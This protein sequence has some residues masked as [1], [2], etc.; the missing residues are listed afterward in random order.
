M[1]KH[2]ETIE[3]TRELVKLASP[4][5]EERDVMGFAL[6][7]LEGQGFNPFIHRYK[8]RTAV[9]F[10]GENVVCALEGRQGGPV[11]CLNGHL[12]TVRLAHGWTRDPYGAEIADGK[13][14]G[15]GA[16]DMKS[17]CAA[18]M[19]ALRNFVKNNADFAGKVILTLV[20][21][22]EGPYGLGT[23][24]LIEEGLLNGID[25]AI[26][27]EPSSCFTK[28][29]FPVLC[30][31]AKGAM[32]YQVDFFGKAAHAA[33]PEE[34]INA[35]VDASGFLAEMAGQKG[36]VKDILGEGRICPIAITADGGACSVPD[37]A[38]VTVY[39]HIVNGE[40]V[41]TVITEAEELLKRLKPACEYKISMRPAPTE[42]SSY[43]K[44]YVL[45]EDDRFVIKMQ[46]AISERFTRK[47]S[48]G[49][50]ASVG[51]FNYL[52]TRLGN[53]PTLIIGPDGGNIH[54]AD[55]Y[56]NVDTVGGTADI[57]EL[58]LEKTML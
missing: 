29:D 27:A 43:Y 20:S 6:K 32:A 42:G 25:C 19:I 21:D 49:Y 16:L 24:A 53:V 45:P 34:G 14:Y 35:A 31:G 11:I 3:L 23:N 18:L 44:P 39:R 37:H 2:D 58:F 5:F 1:E 15:V 9:D 41:E 7:W 52:A 8:V 12:D 33:I 47:A 38:M 46:E 51:D 57:L 22:E 13:M 48:I 28:M 17:G 50:L 54:Q 55:E 36:R 10:D 30:L 56:V 4:Y 26:V 40:T